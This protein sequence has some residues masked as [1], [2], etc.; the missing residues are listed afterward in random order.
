MTERPAPGW[1]AFPDEVAPALEGVQVARFA[2]VCGHALP[3]ALAA[4]GR[5][6]CEIHL[7]DLDRS[8]APVA[9]RSVWVVR[10]RAA[11]MAAGV[12]EAK[13]VEGGA[14]PW[15][16]IAN[17][18][19]F[20]DA[21]KAGGLA[22][23]LD[24]G[25]HP[26]TRLIT[27][28]RKTSGAFPFLS[29]YGRATVL[30]RRV[31]AGR[32]VARA[33]F[34]PHAPDAAIPADTA[35]PPPPTDPPPADPPV[36]AGAAPGWAE[37]ARTLAGPEGFFCDGGAHSLLFVPRSDTLVV[38][39]DNL[40]LAM[41]KRDDRRPWGFGF[42]E[43]QGWSMLGVMAEGWT[44]YRD[45]W[46][47]GQFDRLAAEGFFA[48]FRRVVF[49]GASMGG[50]AACAFSAA[51]P[52]CDVVAISPQ[53]TLDRGLVPWETRYRT[54][55]GRDFSGPYGDAAV[56]SRAARRVALL[57]D[58]YESL[59]AAHVARF[60]GANVVRLRA[61]LLGHR[62]GSALLQ[63]GILTPII[64]GAL[65]GTLEPSAYYRLL[66]ARR[67]FPRYRRELFRKALARGRPELARRVGRWVLAQGED[68]QIRRALRDL[69]PPPLVAGGAGAA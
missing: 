16:L 1:P 27:D 52:G 31:V 55:W 49:Y 39:F 42:I 4:Y 41:E 20:G 63:I 33:L 25:L 47:W 67:A 48:R 24:G 65:N 2:D 32:E 29:R 8:G 43:K 69:P 9:R 19:G 23:V 37:I 64:L 54:A 59:D 34:R 18:E 53:S 50:Y 56:A 35:P 36:A 13:I 3:L 40:D 66:R 21:W 46:V 22:G 7:L 60:E 12:P 38:T 11:L 6:G 68:R 15:D 51:C 28:I 57:Y 17:L 26:G 62:L 45:P 14:G 61:P 44:W 10:Y 5:W 58:P 30:S